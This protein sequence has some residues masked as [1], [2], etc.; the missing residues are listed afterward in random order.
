VRFL[1][2]DDEEQAKRAKAL[3]DGWTDASPGFVSTAVAVELHWV[4][5]RSYG[6][7]API[8]IDV[9]RRLVGMPQVR[10]QDPDVVRRALDSAEQGA[11][12]AD[13]VIAQTAVAAGCLGTV[14]FDR[15][16]ARAAGMTLLA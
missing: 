7:S 9:F 4:L 8:A 2:R 15:A 10:F 6:Y 1:V 14:T 13:A 16:A 11:D 3:I 5:R 12:F